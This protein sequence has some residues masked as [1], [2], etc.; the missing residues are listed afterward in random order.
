MNTNKFKL[1]IIIIT[2]LILF[3]L[4]AS[5]FLTSSAIDA[6]TENEIQKGRTCVII[7]AGH[8]GEDGGTTG[9]N[10]VLEK[11]L[12]LDLSKR[13]D[14]LFGYS[15][16]RFSKRRFFLTHLSV[17]PFAAMAVWARGGTVPRRGILGN[18]SERS[19]SSR[20]IVS[21]SSAT[22]KHA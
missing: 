21:S 8:G 5:A 14:E 15:G 20:T 16:N 11:E 7:D 13:L 10:G 9:G 6:Y 12:N 22:K 3:A 19:S 2:V 1:A 4:V 18:A 17:P